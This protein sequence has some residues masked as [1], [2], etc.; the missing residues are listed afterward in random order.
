VTSHVRIRATALFSV[1]ALVAGL[2]AAPV[3]AAPPPSGK[4]STSKAILYA[5]DGMRPDLME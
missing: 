4:P 1:I 5:S 3:V 2:V